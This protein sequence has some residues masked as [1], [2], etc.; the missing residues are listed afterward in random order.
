MNKTILITGSA[1]F[2]G[3][4]AVLEFSKLGYHV[5][6]IDNLNTY[7]DVR[8]KLARL[9]KQGVDTSNIEY[10]KIV[11]GNGQIEFVQLDISDKS[12]LDTLF[13]KYSFDTVLNLAA[14]AGVRYSLENPDAYLESNV[15]GFLNILECAKK[16]KVKHLVFASSSSVYGSNKKVPFEE[17][18]QTDQQ[19]SLYAA[20]K[21]ANEAMAHSYAS[22]YGM[23]ISGLRFFTVYGPYGRPDMALS[24]I[25]I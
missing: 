5:V 23:K 6:G 20:T 16:S 22:V 7:Y 18:D 24:L 2:I 11:K 25:H 8:L 4:H 17:S 14:Q 10:N 15:T 19:E 3:M 9:E 12:S 1:G 21:K 13:L